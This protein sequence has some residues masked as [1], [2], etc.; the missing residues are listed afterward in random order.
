LH[1]KNDASFV[2]LHTLDEGD[3]AHHVN[4]LFKSLLS[5]QNITKEADETTPKKVMQAILNSRF[6]V[7]IEAKDKAI[8]PI[9]QIPTAFILSS[10]MAFEGVERGA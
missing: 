6:G 1:E 5:L 9:P 2:K 8:V 10:S 7:K 4:V 3:H